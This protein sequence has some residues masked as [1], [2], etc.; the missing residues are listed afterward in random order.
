MLTPIEKATNV[1]NSLGY[2]HKNSG[3]FFH[4]NT[5]TKV[6]F[7]SAYPP[8]IEISNFT[9]IIRI[10]DQQTAVVYKEKKYIGFLNDIIE[11]YENDKLFQL[12]LIDEYFT[13]LAI[14]M[15]KSTFDFKELVNQIKEL[16][17]S[18]Y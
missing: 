9:I 5:L 7:Y 11:S 15:N 3:H 12:S 8:D 2:T 4:P 13:E 17:W 18:S 10:Y 1:M 16:R 6:T 14:L